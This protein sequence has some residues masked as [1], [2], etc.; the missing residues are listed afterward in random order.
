MNLELLISC[1]VARLNRLLGRLTD[2]FTRLAERFKD[3]LVLPVE[4]NDL[5]GLFYIFRLG[6]LWLDILRLLVT[7]PTVLFLLLLHFEVKFEV[8][9]EI[10]RHYRRA[11][12]L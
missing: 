10:V 12:F 11:H 7:V 5:S 6:I 2:A 9:V 3:A 8:Q 4:D 1:I